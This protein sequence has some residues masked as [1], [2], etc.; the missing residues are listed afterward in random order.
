MIA[1]LIGNETLRAFW[2]QTYY[3]AASTWHRVGT[4]LGAEV[5]QA[6]LSEL[7]DV[8]TALENDDAEA[9]G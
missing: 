3:Q 8:A 9:I 1:S 6:L 2:W 4:L 7:Q 5:V